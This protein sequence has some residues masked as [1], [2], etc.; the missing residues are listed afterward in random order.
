MA[1]LA[2]SAQSVI[3]GDHWSSRARNRF[4]TLVHGHS[5]IVTLYSILHGI[6]RV[7][8]HVSM[9]SGDI[10]VADLLV[11]EGYAQ[12][13]PESLES[14]VTGKKKTHFGVTNVDLPIPVEARA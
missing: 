6:M 8:L 10:S 2:P 11:Q 14:K 9:E 7:H 4:I 1:F 12:H 3:L 5:L 13:A